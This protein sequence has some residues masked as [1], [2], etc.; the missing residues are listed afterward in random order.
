[1]HMDLLLLH[2]FMLNDHPPPYVSSILHVLVERR[3]CEWTLWRT[4]WL[5]SLNNDSTV[6]FQTQ[7]EQHL[8]NMWRSKPNAVRAQRSSSVCTHG[9]RA[10]KLPSPCD[11]APFKLSLLPF[12]SDCSGHCYYQTI[13]TPVSLPDSPCSRIPHTVTLVSIP[14]SAE[15][16]NGHKGRGFSVAIDQPLS[17]T[18]GY[19][20]EHGHTVRVSQWVYQSSI[21]WRTK[22][23][24][25]SSENGGWC[26]R[27]SLNV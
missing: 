24:E 25:G 8:V 4:F 17:P 1:M 20:P 2:L 16:N 26:D 23:G 11:R 14:A 10:R 7:Q 15:G 6:L 19:S 9:C 12:L 13:V 5:I 27:W 3:V 18:N 22:D 21:V